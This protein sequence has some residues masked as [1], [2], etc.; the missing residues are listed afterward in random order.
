MASNLEKNYSQYLKKQRIFGRAFKN[1]LIQLKKFYIPI[2]QNIYNRY[3]KSNNTLIIG[4]SGGQG[5]GK[6]TMAQILKI[7][8]R[9]KFSLNVVC[10]SID[11]FYKTKKERVLM[12]QKVHPLFLTRG[13]PG[14]HDHKMIYSSLKNLKSKNFKSLRIPQFDKSRDNRKNKKNWIKIKKKP[15]II[16][17][18]GWC[19]GAKPQTLHELKK[20][21]NLLEKK[22]DTNKSW[23]IK[24]NK[25]LKLNYKKIFKLIDN[26]IYLKV[27]SYNHVLK[28]RLLQE[29]KLRY[30][31]KSKNVMN[32]KQIKNFI[33]HFERVTKSMMKNIKKN[34]V[35]INL[36]NQHKIK[37][38]IN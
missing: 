4:L 34:D 14:T 12:S 37:S 7:I 25:E 2:C 27:P 5:S 36:D 33:M 10:F 28:W 11:D 23:R 19:L 26:L 24:V 16:I 13:V 15:N 18:E 21:V 20:P 32:N 8:L 17:F 29:K 6:S 1:K 30:S 35:I 3:K 38:I 31:N 22:R 9:D